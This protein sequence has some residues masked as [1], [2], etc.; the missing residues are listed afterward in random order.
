MASSQLHNPTA[1]WFLGAPVSKAIAL[2]TVAVYALAE[3][4]NWHDA[5]ILG[6]WIGFD[7]SPDLILS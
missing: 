4:K 5:L 1:A 7:L 6:K 3:M 2:S